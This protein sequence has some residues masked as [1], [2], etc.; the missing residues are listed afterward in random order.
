MHVHGE[1][2]IKTTPSRVLIFKVWDCWNE[3]AARRFALDVKATAAPWLGD[4]WAVFADQLDWGLAVPGAEP[5]LQELNQWG[6]SNGCTRVAQ[7]TGHRTLTEYQRKRV[8]VSTP[9][10]FET[11]ILDSLE[12]GADWLSREGF[13]L[14]IDD[15]LLERPTPVSS[16]I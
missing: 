4:R 10:G 11:R 14:T 15:V 13:A 6:V 7:I 16:L 3:Q 2:R 9:D 1:W 12:D 5:I 8:I